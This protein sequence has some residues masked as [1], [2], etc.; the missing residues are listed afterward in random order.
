MNIRLA[1]Y[2][3]LKAI[4]VPEPKIDAVIQAMETALQSPPIVESDPDVEH[5]RSELSRVASD[6]TLNIGTMMFPVVAVVF[7]LM[8][9]IH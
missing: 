2:Q 3:A 9:M 6:L 5:F 8:V 4:D 7:V 1:L